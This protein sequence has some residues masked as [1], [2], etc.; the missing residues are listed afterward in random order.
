MHTSPHNTDNIRRKQSSVQICSDGAF[1]VSVNENLHFNCNS[2]GLHARRLPTLL[3]DI[4]DR[5][6]PDKHADVT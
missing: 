1:I 2:E 3:E 4:I 5:L 6:T